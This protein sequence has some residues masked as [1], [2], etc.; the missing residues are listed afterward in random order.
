[1]MSMVM[2]DELLSYAY[3]AKI[4]LKCLFNKPRH[5]A[6]TYLYDENEVLSN[7]KSACI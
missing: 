6:T 1:M 7:N 4:P 3:N 5:Y 2:T